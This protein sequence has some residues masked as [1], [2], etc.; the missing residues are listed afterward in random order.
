MWHTAPAAPAAAAW[1]IS[2]SAVA[3]GPQAATTVRLRLA[4]HAAR[5]GAGSW[6]HAVGSMPLR[7]VTEACCSV[8]FNASPAEMGPAGP[9]PGSSG[10]VE[11]PEPELS[12]L[13]D[14]A[15]V[16]T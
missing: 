10:A 12:H 6:V 14:I 7:R 8:A 3:R 15:K 13:K 5:A 4:V 16:W 1:M 2:T 9:D 11:L